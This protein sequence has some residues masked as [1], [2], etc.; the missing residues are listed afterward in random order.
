MNNYNHLSPIIELFQIA[1]ELHQFSNLTKLGSTFGTEP[2]LSHV[3]EVTGNAQKQARQRQE[4]RF[5]QQAPATTVP[6]TL[7][8]QLSPSHLY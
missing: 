6:G 7:T 2:V 3:A 5:R 8:S 4:Q 1:L